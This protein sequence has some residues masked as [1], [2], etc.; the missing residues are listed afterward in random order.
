MKWAHIIADLDDIVET[1]DLHLPE[2]HNAETASKSLLAS[3]KSS[4]FWRRS[5]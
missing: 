2:A 3:G 1:L 4:T 5:T